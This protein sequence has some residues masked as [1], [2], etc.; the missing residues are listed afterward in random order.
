IIHFFSMINSPKNL[1]LFYL[2]LETILLLMLWFYIHKKSPNYFQNIRLLAAFYI[3][4]LILYEGFLNRHYDLL[5][6]FMILIALVFYNDHK[7]K[8]HILFFAIGI[9]FKGYA[10]LYLPFFKKS[11]FKILSLWLS[12]ETL[13]YLWYP[14]RFLKKSSLN[15]FINQWEFNNGLFTYTR[16]YLESIYPFQ[17]ALLYSRYIF[18]FLFLFFFSILFFLWI[19]KNIKNNVFILVT[20]LFYL[21]NP[22]ANPWY[23][24]MAVPIFV[25]FCENHKYHFF[26]SLLSLYYLFYIPETP[27]ESLLLISLVTWFVLI[28]IVLPDKK[29]KI[30]TNS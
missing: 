13:S 30:I 22:V 25:N 27:L 29:S 2:F 24:L 20:I 9:H 5:I 4:P 15:T 7:N 1:V 18:L 28:L 16:I 19:K 21:C 17:E 8:L 23:F 11:R 14:A 6:A 12:L 3:H 26:L 10:L